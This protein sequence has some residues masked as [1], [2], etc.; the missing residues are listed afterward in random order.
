M[1]VGLQQIQHDEGEGDQMKIVSRDGWNLDASFRAK[2]F[3]R[4]AERWPRW[5][6]SAPRWGRMSKT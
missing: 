1:M 4:V 3:D 6:N 5:Q 2:H